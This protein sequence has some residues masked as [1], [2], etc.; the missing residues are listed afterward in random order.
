M[1]DLRPWVA[2]LGF[3]IV[4]AAVVVAVARARGWRWEWW[5]RFLSPRK[6]PPS[7][8]VG[9]WTPPEGGGEAPGEADVRAAAAREALGL[10]QIPLLDPLMEPRITALERDPD[11][12]GIE[13]GQDLGD[14]DALPEERPAA[15]PSPDPHPHGEDAL[16]VDD[17]LLVVLTILTPNERSLSGADIRR[18]FSAFDLEADEA[19][20]FH[21][22]GSR[23]D[24]ARRP[25]FSAANVLEPGVF[26]VARMEEVET[27][28]LCLFMRRPGPLPAGVAFDLML[29]VGNRLARVLGAVLCDDRRCRLTLQGTQA[30]RERVE[31]YA[32]RRERGAA[33]PA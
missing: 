22:Y 13:D 9:D 27:P 3:A 11:L 10:G 2:V 16:P 1:E 31:L 30:I 5:E 4:A 28:G 8:S 19:G 17:E 14:L 26:D 20:L 32:L 25:V 21:H 6:R 12:G 29:D 15:A 33:R 24:E 7:G 23:R 18:A